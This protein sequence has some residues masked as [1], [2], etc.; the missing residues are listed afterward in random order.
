MPELFYYKSM[1]NIIGIDIGTTNIEYIL[2][3][4]KK[5]PICDL[6]TPNPL[7]AFGLDVMTRISKANDGR[8]HEMTSLLRVTIKND[9]IKLMDE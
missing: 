5:G 4:E 2:A 7:S 1:R 6:L 3:D 8:L 9:I